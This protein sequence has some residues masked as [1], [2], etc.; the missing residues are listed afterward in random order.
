MCVVLTGLFLTGLGGGRLGES[1]EE[2]RELLEA[3]EIAQEDTMKNH[4]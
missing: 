3:L 2:N 1:E 4:Q